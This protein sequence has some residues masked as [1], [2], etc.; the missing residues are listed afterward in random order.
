[1]GSLADRFVACPQCERKYMDRVLRIQ[2][3]DPF[4][5]TM[6][7]MTHECCRPIGCGLAV[8]TTAHILPVAVRNI[9]Q[10]ERDL[11]CDATHHV[12]SVRRITMSKREG[13]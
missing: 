13:E 3:C 2:R 6:L 1:M 10:I 12:E 11:L 4:D 9:E 8:S 7:I 5:V